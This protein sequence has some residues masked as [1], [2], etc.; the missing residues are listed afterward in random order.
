MRRKRKKKSASALPKKPFKSRTERRFSPAEV[1]FDAGVTKS[2]AGCGRRLYWHIRV[3]ASEVGHAYV[4]I[5]PAEGRDQRASVT[6]LLNAKSRGLG[7]GTIAFRRAAELS[8]C[9]KVYAIIAKLNVA[10]RVAAQRA[11]YQPIPDQ[12]SGQ[13]TLIWEK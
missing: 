1:S 6:V 9:D 12:P 13:L 4:D 10:S 2:L 5:I 11:G 8:G 7:I 3:D